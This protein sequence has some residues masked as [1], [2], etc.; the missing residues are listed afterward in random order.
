MTVN[1]VFKPTTQEVGIDKYKSWYLIHDVFVS[2]LQLE[3]AFIHCYFC[4]LIC[5]FE[6]CI[7]LMR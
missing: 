2:Y 5:C 4:V 1:S 3:L 6:I 7:D